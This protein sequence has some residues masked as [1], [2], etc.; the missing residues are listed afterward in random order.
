[1]VDVFA[2]CILEPCCEKTEHPPQG[3]GLLHHHRHNRPGPDNSARAVRGW[4]RRLLRRTL[5]VAGAAMPRPALLP[6]VRD[7]AAAGVFLAA[8]TTTTDGDTT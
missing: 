3:F 4:V 5:T 7:D 8:N 2:V 6:D 1:M